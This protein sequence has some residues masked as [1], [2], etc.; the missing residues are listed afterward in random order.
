MCFQASG[1]GCGLR[2]TRKT[3]CF[4]MYGV[5]FWAMRVSKHDGNPCRGPTGSEG[6]SEEHLGRAPLLL[7]KGPCFFG[8][9]RIE[10]PCSVLL[11]AKS[12]SGLGACWRRLQ[13]SGSPTPPAS[14]LRALFFGTLASDW[15]PTRL[16]KRPNKPCLQACVSL[17][18]I[19]GRGR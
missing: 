4:F 1:P 13:G 14:K 19:R 3:H 17:Q 15:E 7:G 2:A 8:H 9:G 12:R 18:F 11:G 10:G 16:R 5:F 6:S